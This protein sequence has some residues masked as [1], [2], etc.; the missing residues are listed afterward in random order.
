MTDSKGGVT[1]VGLHLFFLLH[2]HSEFSELSPP[3]TQGVTP[4]PSATRQAVTKRRHMSIYT[5][6]L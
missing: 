3:R 4:I 6:F 5:D 1:H 2:T